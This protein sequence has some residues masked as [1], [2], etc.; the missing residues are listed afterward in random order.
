MISLLIGIYVL[1]IIFFVGAFWWN[2]ER[3]FR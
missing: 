1:A 3:T 2:G